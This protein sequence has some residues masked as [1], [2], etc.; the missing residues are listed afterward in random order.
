MRNL[1]FTLLFVFAIG[2][3]AN[4][5][6]TFTLSADTLTESVELPEIFASAHSTVT[7]LASGP[8]TIN[9][10][11]FILSLS[12]GCIIQ[13]CDPN[14]CYLPTENSKNF[15]LAVNGVGNMIVDLIDT[16]AVPQPGTAIVRMKYTN[17]GQTS[18]TA[19]TYYFLSITGTSGTGDLSTAVR[20]VL[21]PNPVTEWFALA[22]A[23]AVQSV[24]VYNA[25]GQ[26]VAQFV[27]TPGQRYSLAGQPTGTYFIALTD[28]NGKVLRALKVKKD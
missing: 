26:Q 1:F 17:L 27:A 22:D 16:S 15:T 8:I 19:S 5:Q 10:T 28:K 21:Y 7:N 11:R 23:D 3:S 12:P 14:N 9:W 24:R 20:V 18:D 13:V 2:I 25:Q 6:S 4:A